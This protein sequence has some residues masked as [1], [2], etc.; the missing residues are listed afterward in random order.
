MFELSIGESIGLLRRRRKMSILDL[1]EKSGVNRN[2]IS[3][4]ENGESANV[5]I[6]TLKSIYAA[7]GHR[8]YFSIL[9]IEETDMQNENEEKCDE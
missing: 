7:M 2:T 8:I 3:Q 1:A 6:E 5:T 4:L 9:P